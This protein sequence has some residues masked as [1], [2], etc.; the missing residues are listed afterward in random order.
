M[1]HNK[2]DVKQRVIILSAAAVLLITSLMLSW[3]YRPFVYNNDINDFHFADN[4]LNLFFIPTATLFV[5][6]VS[7]KIAYS[8]ALIGSTVGFI[9]F[10]LLD[11]LFVLPDIYTIIAVL[12]GALIT[13]G[14][15]KLFKIK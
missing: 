10:R 15:G 5:R 4:I 2:I 13:F 1:E 3:F 8:E 9:I 6:G 7:R 12:L 11:A 14:I